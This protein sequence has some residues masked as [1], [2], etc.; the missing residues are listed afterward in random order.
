MVLK[1]ICIQGPS[2]DLY[3]R[4]LSCVRLFVTAWTAACQAPVSMYFSRQEFW[5]GLP[6]PSPDI[7][8]IQL[9]VTIIGTSLVFK[10]LRLCA[11]DAGGMGVIPSQG[12]GSYMLQLK[13]PSAE[14]KTPHC[15]I[16]LKKIAIIIAML[17]QYFKDLLTR[18]ILPYLYIDEGL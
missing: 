14:T 3:A 7:A 18:R 9:K 8:S 15:Q 4:M 16:N 2:L 17:I 6:F 11:P 12:T 10:W 5:I 13:I 1:M